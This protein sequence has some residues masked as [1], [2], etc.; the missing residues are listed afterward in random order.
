M[1]FFI[2]EKGLLFNVLIFSLYVMV[3][4]MKYAA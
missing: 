3:D 4:F 2:V 1:V